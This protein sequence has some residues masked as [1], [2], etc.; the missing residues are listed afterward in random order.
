MKIA[1]KSPIASSTF[2][3]GLCLALVCGLPAGADDATASGR[4]MKSDADIALHD[5]ELRRL[6]D[7]TPHEL[8]QELAGKVYI[9]DGLT[10]KEVDQGLDKN[11][12]RIQSMMFVGTVK[13]EE[14]GSP[15]TN[16]ETGSPVQESGGCGN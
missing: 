4:V 5:W 16:S 2:T 7:P 12:P 11:F 3:I 14:Q 13:T 8:Q 10:D 9:Y 15:L 6:V 1:I